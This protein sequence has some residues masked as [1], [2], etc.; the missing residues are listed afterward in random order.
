LT[1]EYDSEEHLYQQNLATQYLTPPG[2]SR[3]SD[4]LVAALKSCKAAA[5]KPTSLKRTA[6]G[7]GD[8]TGCV[9]EE[10]ARA[11]KSGVGEETEEAA[12]S[13]MK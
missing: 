8:R 4:G 9:L 6:L 10:R 11:G 5:T 7:A 2:D 12:R 3:S 13:E 1:S